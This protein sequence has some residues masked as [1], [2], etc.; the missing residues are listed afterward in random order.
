MLNKLRSVALVAA[1]F[2]C[3]TSAKAV[4]ITIAFVGQSLCAEMFSVSSS[5]PTPLSGTSMWANGSTS[6]TAVTG[7]GAIQY[8]NRIK[9]AT[10]ATNVRLYN[11]CFGGSALLSA[12]ASPAANYWLNT[13]SG[14][15]LDLFYTMVSNSGVVPDLIEYNQ[16]QQ[17]YMSSLPN[18][19]GDYEAGLGSLRSM[20]LSHFGK[21]AAQLPWQQWVTGKAAY[22]QAGSTYVNAAQIRYG[23]SGA[24]GV[25][26]GPSYYDLTYVDGTHL[27]AASY[28]TN[29]DRGAVG[30]LRLLGATG[31]TRPGSGPSITSAIRSSNLVL[32]GTNAASILGHRAPLYPKSPFN[33]TTNISGFTVWNSSYSSTIAVNA[34]QTIGD[35]VLL[36][37]AS[38]PGAGAH[39]GYQ[40]DNA[41]NASN[42]IYDD[43]DPFSTGFGL[44]LTPLTIQVSTN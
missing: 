16:G 37:L 3:S 8:A 42:P 15:P 35:M 31:F 34:A 5:P 2:L 18:L 38:D 6:W 22:G 4:D 1:L 36:T 28:Q 26:L 17:D 19:L 29:G 27:N 24:A 11:A 43:N 32:L 20:I 7:N 13:A 39:V 44:P 21:T 12:D 40:W 41:Y 9:T 25:A 10:G 33:N 14:A 23:L 30:A